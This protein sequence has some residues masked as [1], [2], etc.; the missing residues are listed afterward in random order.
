MFKVNAEELR[1]ELKEK[2]AR[3]NKIDEELKEMAKTEEKKPGRKLF[4]V[5]MYDPREVPPDWKKLEEYSTFDQD[6]D[7]GEAFAVS[8]SDPYHEYY[9]GSD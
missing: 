2:M 3:L 9:W 7:V 6:E 1:K 4:W 5:E 8:E